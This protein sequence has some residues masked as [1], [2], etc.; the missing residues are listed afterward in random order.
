MKMR[1]EDIDIPEVPIPR[2]I[3]LAQ[4]KR[5]AALKRT[6]VKLSTKCA[7]SRPILAVKKKPQ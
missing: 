1:V 5:I 4:K 3:M 2:R 6:N 7:K